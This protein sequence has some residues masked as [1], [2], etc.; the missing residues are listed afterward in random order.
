MA[1]VTSTKLAQLA[2]DGYTD[3]D[4]DVLENYLTVTNALLSADYDGDQYMPA[5]DEAMWCP[6][7]VIAF[8]SQQDRS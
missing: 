5:K 4:Y 6:D 2:E 3:S 8:L 1:R 7:E